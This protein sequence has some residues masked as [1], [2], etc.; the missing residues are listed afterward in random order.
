M[1]Y[2]KEIIAYR[3]R[4]VVQEDGGDIKFINFDEEK[5]I[6]YLAMKGSCS[7]CPSSGVTLKHG[8]EKML[9]HYVAGVKEV[10]PVDDE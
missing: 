5:G 9:V 3:I 1:K 10:E 4:P 7:G 8:I 6:V 2:I